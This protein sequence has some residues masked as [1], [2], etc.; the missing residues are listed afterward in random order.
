MTDPVTVDSEEITPV[1]ASPSNVTPV[2]SPKV[3]QPKSVVNDNF[4]CK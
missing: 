2:K 4:G 3:V 1:V